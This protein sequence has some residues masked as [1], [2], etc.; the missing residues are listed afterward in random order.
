MTDAKHP[1]GEPWQW[2]EPTWRRIFGRAHPGR[3]LA[4][5]AWPGGAR[6][7]FAMSFDADH[8]SS[9][10]SRMPV[11]GKLLAHAKRRGSCWFATHA[12]VA[13]WC[14]ENAAA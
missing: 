14:K 13:R 11:L 9:H 10:R 3:S 6:C 8:V 4:P 12:D 7:A 1:E 5:E 2:S